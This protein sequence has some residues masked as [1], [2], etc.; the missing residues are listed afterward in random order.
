MNERLVSPAAVH[1]VCFL[2]CGQKFLI[3]LQFNF[4]ARLKK[5]PCRLVLFFCFLVRVQ[6]IV[7]NVP[8]WAQAIF[9]LLRIRSVWENMGSRKRWLQRGYEAGWFQLN[10][11]M[12]YM[13]SYHWSCFVIR[14]PSPACRSKWHSCRVHFAEFSL[15]SDIWYPGR[16]FLRYGKRPYYND[17]L[18]HSMGGRE[19][20][21]MKRRWVYLSSTRFIQNAS[22]FR[23]V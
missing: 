8:I 18:S 13:Y 3:T 16:R 15:C 9:N 22:T 1:S 21:I 14:I 20:G 6:S 4:L 12:Q 23:I 17:Q 2:V 19:G 10:V 5:K 11:N 7:L